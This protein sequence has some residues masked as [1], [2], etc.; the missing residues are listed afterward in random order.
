MKVGNRR[1][2]F[3]RQEG[4]VPQGAVSSPILFIL[5]VE[6]A[7]R[8]ILPVAESLGIHIGMYA[9]DLTVWKT[10]NDIGHLSKSITELLQRTLAPEFEYLHF[11]L[12]PDKCKSFLFTTHR[13]DPWPC[14]WLKA[15]T[16]KTGSHLQT[17]KSPEFPANKNKK[18]SIRILGVFFDQQLTFSEHLRVIESR[19]TKKL[20]L[21]ARMSN[22]LWGPSQ[23][24]MRTAYI[25]FI[26]STL[27]YCGPVWFPCL[28]PSQIE[29]LEIIQRKGLRI[30]LGVKRCSSNN[31]VLLE[32]NL[33]P[34][35]SRLRIT[36]AMQAEKY[37]RYPPDD[38]LFRLAHQALQPKRLKLRSSWQYL[39]DSILQ[40][41]GFYPARH[42]LHG[43]TSPTSARLISLAPHSPY[44][45]TSAIAPWDLE[46]F[47]DHI[48]VKPQ[49]ANIKLKTEPKNLKRK[50]EEA[51]IKYGPY[52]HAFWTDGS[53]SGQNHFSARACNSYAAKQSV[54]HP[55]PNTSHTYT[56][57]TT[58][59][60]AAS[61]TPEVKAL[62]HPPEIISANPFPY[63]H[64][65]I[66]IGTD[67]QSSLTGF[68]PLKRPKFGKLDITPT[69]KSNLDISRK[70][71]ITMHFQ[72]VPAHI[73]IS[74]NEEA[75]CL[76]N[77]LRS[78]ST[79]NM[80]VQ[81][82][83]EPAS[84]KTFLKQYEREK[85]QRSILTSH[86]HHTGSRIRT[87]GIKKT[88]F[89]AREGTP[90]A[91]QCLFSRWRLGQVDSCGSYPRHL[92]FIEDDDRLC[93][94][95]YSANETTLHLCATC[96]ALQTYRAAHN[97]SLD[98]LY[99][100]SKHNILTIAAFDNYISNIL[101]YVTHPPIQP[102]L[103]CSY[104]S[105]LKRKYTTTKIPKGTPVTEPPTKYPRSPSTNRRKRHLI[106]PMT[107]TSS[108]EP[109]RKKI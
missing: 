61:Y 81:H 45:V 4:G 28:S 15:R 66:F 40:D 79:I 22:S 8:K 76:A 6:T 20:H 43:L 54:L 62:N 38:P 47:D 34:V 2:K 93:R 102:S 105:T 88:N 27:E 68:D 17:M 89:Q 31:D 26:R 87:A 7:I 55:I 63:R 57:S 94:F 90:R 32:S 36:T 46:D 101:P 49:L 70:Y 53:M 92:G 33:L 98:T 74:G 12:H 78:A 19:A 77:E 83:I 10:G 109:P 13:K 41:A 91:L 75:N 107:I 71:D 23:T 69:I 108:H 30:A 37:R 58:G 95:C 85:F 56:G 24:N 18:L 1:S 35:Q 59:L 80:Q 42:D 72:W 60:V 96:P 64:S 50:A 14:I 65:N 99:T 48:M 3:C 39:S 97:I 106:I 86:N 52:D 21:L 104:L 11:N 9:D 103:H 44:Q 67:S 16:Q 73:G 5:Y 51:L 82:E 25:A 29:R 100:D 84:L